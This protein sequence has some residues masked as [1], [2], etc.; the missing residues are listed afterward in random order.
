MP[1][2]AGYPLLIKA[3]EEA[4]ET[5]TAAIN[6]LASYDKAVVDAINKNFYIELATAIHSYTMSAVV[7][8][9]VLGGMYGIA[10]PIVPMVSVSAPV[11][12][13]IAGVG[14]GNLL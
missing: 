8:T 10:A 11:F 9:T 2:A 6:A 12:G 1:L 3:I 4:F 7:S 13:P 14:T 5:K